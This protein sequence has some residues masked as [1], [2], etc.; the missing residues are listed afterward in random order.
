MTAQTTDQAEPCVEGQASWIQGENGFTSAWV[1][2]PDNGHAIGSVVLVPPHG[3]EAVIAFRALRVLAIELARAGFVCV[4]FALRGDGDSSPLIGADTAADWRADVSGAITVAQELVPD[5]GVSV[6][7]LRLGAGVTAN[8]SDDRIHSRLLWEPVDGRLFLREQSILR[9]LSVP[10]PPVAKEDGVELVGT[11]FSPD[12]ARSVRGIKGTESGAADTVVRREY[13]RE[14]AARL[15]AVVTRDAEIPRQSLRDIVDSLPRTTPRPMRPW[16]PTRDIRLGVRGVQVVKSHVVVGPHHLPGVVTRPADHPPKVGVIYSAAG[17]EPKDGPTGLW[18][19]S[20]A[21]AAAH[22]AVTLRA[23]WRLLGD[24]LDEAEDREPNPYK[25]SSITDAVEAVRFVHGG[26]SVPSI[27]VGLCVGGWLF[28]RAAETLGEHEAMDQI[29]AINNVAWQRRTKFYERVYRGPLIKKL[30]R[31]EVNVGP[32][33]T[34]DGQR[35]TLRSKVKQVL[36]SARDSGSK[37]IPTLVWRGMARTGLVQEP[38]SLLARIPRTT[39]VRLVF[40]AEDTFRWGLVRGPSLLPALLS[41]GHHVDVGF[42]PSLDHSLL[43][44][45]SRQWTINRINALVEQY[46]DQPFHHGTGVERGLESR[47]VSSG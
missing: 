4:R 29:L 10:L 19:I 8:L 44:Q 45:E 32:A 15:F 20:A 16:S 18:A 42:E 38:V 21:Q 1:H 35:R 33:A 31:E 3:R 43:A 28:A 24:A 27:G 11:V 7:G 47:G 36:K 26:W 17:A 22:G 12:Q 6:I 9:K 2:A 30:L 37:L 14:V 39:L 46:P 40:G 5:L 25:D 34:V 41:K 13:D 23:D